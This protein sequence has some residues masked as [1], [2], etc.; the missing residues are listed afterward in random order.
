MAV[1]RSLDFE[2]ILR[3]KPT[4]FAD[5]LLKIMRKR[6]EPKIMSRFLVGIT[7][8]TKE[9]IIEVGK[10]GRNKVRAVD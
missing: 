1:V 9:V 8:N 3:L 5:E 2:Y 10:T 7:R 4:A 6:E